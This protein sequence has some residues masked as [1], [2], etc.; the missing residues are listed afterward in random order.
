MKNVIKF[1]TKRSE[2]KNIKPKMYLLKLD[3]KMHKAIKKIAKSES[4]TIKSL[5]LEPLIKKHNL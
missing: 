4:K 2:N 3:A 1:Q 5:L